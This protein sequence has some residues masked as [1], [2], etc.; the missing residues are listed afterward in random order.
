MNVALIPV[1]G[2]SKS[3]PLKNIKEIAGK[4]LV[5]WAAKAACECQ[6]IDK[7]YIAT[8]SEQIRAVAQGFGMDK[9]CVIGRSAA[10]ASDQASTETVML[11]FA[12]QYSFDN[13]VLIQA[14]SPLITAADLDGG[15]REFA[16][17]DTDSVLST[18]RQK[19]FF[20]QKTEE[21]CVLPDNYDIYKRPRRQ[22]FEGILVENGAFYITG[23]QRLLETGNR[24]SGRIRTYEMDEATYFE[25]D[26]M[27]DWVIIE[28]LLDK[29]ERGEKQQ[30]PDIKMFLTDCDGCLTDGGMYYSENGD[31][32][33]KFNARDGM[34]MSLLKERG[35]LT[36]I[37]TGENCSLNERRAKKLKMD[38]YE[39]GVQD[40]L[41]RVQAL[42][43]R[44][45]VAM[46]NV[47][48]VGDDINDLEVIKNVGFGCSVNN[49]DGKVKAAAR[50]V[51]KRNGG[52]GAV[53]EIIDLIIQ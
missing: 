21:G 6:A 2:G 43:A 48:Y 14:T 33:K 26:E 51:S 47:A 50:Y 38:I 39:P 13:I 27:S 20:W 7:V 32:M 35:I 10:S 49:A 18:V 25:I 46:E 22:E 11:E 9:L 53:R 16:K 15:F 30:I 24:I 52:Q 4:P 29:R 36:G 19:R 12:Q 41:S 37:V 45:G 34:G 31:E 8:D 17:P 44:Y 3:I 40:K 42:C 5:Y 28:Q 1:R 23:R